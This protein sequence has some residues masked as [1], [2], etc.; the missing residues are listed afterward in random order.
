M[1]EHALR[2]VYGE[3]APD[4]VRLKR[5]RR[6]SDILIAAGAII[7]GLGLMP[8]VYAV[9]LVDADVASALN[10][11]SLKHILVNSAANVAVMIWA[12]RLQGRFDR[13]LAAVLIRVLLIHGLIAFWILLARQP[14]SNQV[15]L[16]AAAGSAVLGFGVVLIQQRTRE[17][18]VA[19]VG[20]WHPLVERLQVSC[21]CIDN[22]EADLEHYDVLLTASVAD[23]SPD[24]ART[25]SKAMLT[26]KSV[27]LLAEFVEEAHGIVSL[28]HFDLEHLPVAGLTSYRTR[29]RLMDI[30]LV[31]LA[32]PVALPLLLLGAFVVLLTMGRP[33]LFS[34]TRVGLGGRVFRMFKL[35]TMR[36]PDDAATA[37]ATGSRDDARI[38]P[39]GRWL[40]RFRID[41]LPQLWN[42]LVG[43]MSFIGPRPE[44]TVLSD[45]Y[46]E[47]LPHYEYRHLVRPGLTGWAQVRSGY[48]A[49]MA[50]TRTKVGYDLFYIKN[51]SFSLDVQILVRTVWT[52]ISGSGAR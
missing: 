15:M 9:L 50:E 19:L 46:V 33:V 31:I 34:Q 38:T 12:I 17:P 24:W 29:K 4:V 40:R 36:L 23:I 6:F 7:V 52:L 42:V 8:L 25:I 28:E 2:R 3:S 43:D 11:S 39:A 20:S 41:E 22:P 26:G 35:R 27:R 21:D 5:R 30:G 37:R 44:W 14:Y 16:M 51:L 10:G 48:A 45:S 47:R 1:I 32:L 18:R 13:R 49:D